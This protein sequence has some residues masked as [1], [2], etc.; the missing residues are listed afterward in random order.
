M[1]LRNNRIVCDLKRVNHARLYWENQRGNKRALKPTLPTAF[2]E[3]FNPTDR[4]WTSDHERN[5]E[6]LIE[7]ARELDILD[8]WF[9]VC[10]LQFNNTHALEYTG[11]KAINIWNAWKERIFKK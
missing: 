3:E 4:V 11:E 5:G 10:K 9:P 2:N 6:T 8:V 1:P 7:R